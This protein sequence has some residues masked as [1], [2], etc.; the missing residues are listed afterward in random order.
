MPSG[1]RAR[2]MDSRASRGWGEYA[3]ACTEITRSNFSHQFFFSIGPTND[4]TAVMG[5]GAL[6]ERPANEKRTWGNSFASSL[7]NFPWPMPTSRTERRARGA[8]AGMRK[9]RRTSAATRWTEIG[10]RSMAPRRLAAWAIC[11][12]SPSRD[13]AS[14]CAYSR[15]P[16]WSGPG[17]CRMLRYW[18]LRNLRPEGESERVH[19]RYAGETTERFRT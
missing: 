10:F 13:V 16:R 4:L 7:K 3:R 5:G 17:A 8:A 6:S 11:R 18:S 12:S 14:H 1:L 19:F 9:N 2:A 15:T